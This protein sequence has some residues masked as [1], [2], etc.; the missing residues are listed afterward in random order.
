MHA[1]TRRRSAVGMAEV[2]NRVT[3]NEDFTR[4][5]RRWAEILKAHL[6]AVKK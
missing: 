2:V 3:N 6:G 4:V 5:V 1:G